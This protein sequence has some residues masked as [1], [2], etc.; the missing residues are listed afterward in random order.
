[1]KKKKSATNVYVCIYQNVCGET[2]E[3][4]EN[5]NV[6]KKRFFLGYSCVSRENEKKKLKNVHRPQYCGL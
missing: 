2:H 1:M 4:N 6:E 3:R 5:E